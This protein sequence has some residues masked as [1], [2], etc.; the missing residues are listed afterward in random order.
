MTAPARI[1]RV[2]F[3]DEQRRNRRTG[4]ITSVLVA[5]ALMTSGI[6]L[7]VLVSPA[8]IAVALI[9]T[10]IADDFDEPLPEDFLLRPLD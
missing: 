6:P 10:Y 7:S 1:D 4:W 9:V 8:L 3:L 2:H 5:L